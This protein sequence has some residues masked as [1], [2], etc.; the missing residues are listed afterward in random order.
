MG[1]S[2]ERDI[3]GYMEALARIRDHA[4]F[5]DSGTTREEMVRDSIRLYLARH[6]PHSD[7]LTREE[8][9]GFRRM[10]GADYVGVGMEIQRSADGDIVCF[11]YAGGPAERAGI[12]RGDRLRSIDSTPVLGKSLPAVAALVKGRQGT[13]LQ[14]TVLRDGGSEVHVR[15]TLD[16][17]RAESVTVQAVEGLRVARVAAFAG[18]TRG[19]LERELREW[20]RREPVVLDLR[21]N[22]GGEFLASID[23][24]MLFLE[25]GAPIASV[26][27][28]QGTEVHESRGGALLALRRPVFL[29][30]DEGT[31]SAAE[32]FIGALVGN[33]KAVSIG[34]RT[35][36]KGTCQEIIEMSDGSALILTTGA[37]RTPDG[38]E[39][40]GIGLGP[41]HELTGEDA[42]TSR[43]VTRVRE[44]TR[45]I[46]PE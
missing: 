3:I 41:T 20:P 33:G 7:Y 29:W 10:R 21:G 39:F 43:Y 26:R 30:Q 9:A 13:E 31:A 22:G 15:V 18:D 46:N 12:R 1:W 2:Q 36:G 8:Y 11:P 44:L 5:L 14:L 28:S 27:T 6:D 19:K 38:R 40:D 45:A 23:A 32:V 24:A 25:E 16:E 42:R 4:L 34:R 35:R 17:A 37:L